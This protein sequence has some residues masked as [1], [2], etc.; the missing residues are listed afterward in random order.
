MVELEVRLPDKSLWCSSSIKFDEDMVK[1]KVKTSS[2]RSTDKTDVQH[3]T[4][5]VSQHC[6]PDESCTCD[7]YGMSQHW[8]QEIEQGRFWFDL[9][10][11]K[12]VLS[13]P[14]IIF[15]LDYWRWEILFSCSMNFICYKILCYICWCNK[16]LRAI[17]H[18]NNRIETVYYVLCYLDNYEIHSVLWQCT[19]LLLNYLWKSELLIQMFAT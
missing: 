11:S 9:F 14:F 5:N 8:M 16:S 2:T 12:Y 18:R 13:L 19:R 15:F 7:L 10:L 6:R 17:I 3:E 4:T 1:H